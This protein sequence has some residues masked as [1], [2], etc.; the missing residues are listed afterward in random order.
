[1]PSKIGFLA[2][3]IYVRSVDGFQVT[4]DLLPVP[5]PSLLVLRKD[6][7]FFPASSPCWALQ[8]VYGRQDG[9]NQFNLIFHPRRIVCA[10]V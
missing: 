3:T 2:I 8:W 10:L 7:F 1:M 6:S 5:P 4:K 9:I